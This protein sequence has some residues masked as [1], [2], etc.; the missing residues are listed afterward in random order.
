MGMPAK[1]R[2]KPGHPRRE[3]EVNVHTV[4][5]K[6]Y[7]HLRTL[8]AS[9][10]HV[11]LHLL[12][13]DTKTPI[14]DQMPRICDRG[15]RKCL[16]NNGDRDTVDLAQ[17]KGRKNRI[18]KICCRHVVGDK[19]DAP[20]QRAVD[21]FLHTRHAVGKFPVASHHINA[22]NKLGRDHVRTAGP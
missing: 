22:Q 1:N 5:G 19:S 11:D 13:L 14:S 16:A 21:Q 12:L 2:I 3:F 15:I 8:G 17:Y 7:H 6:Q 18:A 20:V 9:N 10:I 4:V